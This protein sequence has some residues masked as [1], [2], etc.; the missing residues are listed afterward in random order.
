MNIKY[1]IS[2]DVFV[3]NYFVDTCN[4]VDISVNNNLFSLIILK[5]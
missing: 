3:N 2:N 4:F 5:S 1:V